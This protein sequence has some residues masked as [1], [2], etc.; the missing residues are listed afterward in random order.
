MA[1]A[2]VEH[3][4]VRPDRVRPGLFTAQL[5]RRPGQVDDLRDG[6]PGV[7]GEAVA[8][9]DREEATEV[10]A[11]AVGLVDG[12]DLEL[13]PIGVRAA[14]DDDR[15]ERDECQQQPQRPPPSRTVLH[16][17]SSCIQRSASAAP[18]TSPSRT[19]IKPSHPVKGLGSVRPS[20]ACPAIWS[21]STCTSTTMGRLSG[22]TSPLSASGVGGASG[23]NPN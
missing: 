3:D 22:G 20:P 13:L 12:P 1:V 23:A 7:P 8:V 4:T 11:G 6:G 16:G 18:R 14:S 2:L 9:V 21:P 19:P 17:V 10:E 5:A 15:T